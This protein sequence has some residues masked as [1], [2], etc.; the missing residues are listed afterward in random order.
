MNSGQT[1]QRVRE[2]LKRRIMEGMYPP[3]T[4]L[5][6]ASL[7][8]TLAASSTPVRE[9]LHELAGEGLIETRTGGG[10]HLPF[11]DE[12]GLKDLY[13]WNE[14]ILMLALRKN[15]GLPVAK[16]LDAL[17]EPPADAAAALFLA[18][19]RL[20]TNQEHA[21]AIARL[22]DR[23]HAVRSAEADILEN[24]D[25]ELAQLRDALA[26]DDRPALRRGCS[27]YHR[28]RRRAAAS[29]VRRLHRDA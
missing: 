16:P 25:E 1:E 22:S 10:F 18:I 4:R 19:A 24:V 9:A 2:T 12:P 8:D 14:D 15:A 11:W 6:A 29:L 17:T 26:R 21:R 23:L 13:A 28:R 20:S 3:G 7:S 5:D 27:A